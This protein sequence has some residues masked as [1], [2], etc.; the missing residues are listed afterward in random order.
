MVKNASDTLLTHQNANK[1]PLRGLQV[2]PLWVHL[3]RGKR[4]NIRRTSSKIDIYLELT[5]REVGSNSNEV[6]AV[7]HMW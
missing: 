2:P 6:T 7:S 3:C 4:A 5:L 1:I